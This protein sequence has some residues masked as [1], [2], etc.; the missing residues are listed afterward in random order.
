MGRTVV[1]LS[2]DDGHPKDLDVAG[3]LAELGLR[4]T[5][6]VPVTNVEG[7][8][9][10]SPD[11]IRKL[12]SMGFEIGAH[13][14]THRYLDSLSPADGREEIRAGKER[15]E[16]ILSKPV[17]SFCYPG[18]KIPAWAPGAAREL[19]FTYARTIR[20][21]RF[22]APEPMLAPTTCHMGPHSRRHYLKEALLAGSPAYIAFFLRRG[23]WGRTWDDFALANLDYAMRTGGLWH[24]WG[25][26]YEITEPGE[27]ERLKRVLSAVSALQRDARVVSRTNSESLALDLGD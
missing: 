14:F 21:C 10:L 3:L 26:F 17:T 15:L 19:G 20:E 23:L 7:R 22:A 1:T 4:A 12:D 25:H 8:P 27:W 18:G 11:D 16:R 2:F 5:F 6:Y 24:A 9:T 13:G